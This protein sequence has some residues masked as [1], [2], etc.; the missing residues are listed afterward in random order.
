MSKIGKEMVKDLQGLEKSLRK[1]RKASKSPTARTLEE[2]KT[3]GFDAH[4]VERYN[5]FARRRIDLFNFADIVAMKPGVGI[6]AVQAT[7]N[8][9]GNHSAHI[10]KIQA[11]PKARTWIESGGRIEMWSWAKQGARGKR[12]TWTLRREELTLADLNVP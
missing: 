2:L 3:L 11:E 9:G 12:K 5:R 6:V 4:V 1:K 8:N 7:S 10:K